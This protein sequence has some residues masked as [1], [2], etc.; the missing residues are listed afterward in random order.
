[1]VGPENQRRALVAQK[2]SKKRLSRESVWSYLIEIH[3]VARWCGGLLLL[4][5]F[6]IISTFAVWLLFRLFLRL[7]RE[8]DGVL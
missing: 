2:P 5:C 1:M 6:L 3:R 7:Y 8:L 4:L